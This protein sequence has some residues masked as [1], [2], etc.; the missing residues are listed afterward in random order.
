MFSYPPSSPD[1]VPVHYF[2]SPKL[3][4]ATKG[5][6]FEV[7]SSLQQTVIRELKT[8]QEDTSSRTSC[9]V[10]MSDVNVVPKEAGTILSYG[11]N[12][13]FY[14]TSV[15]FGPMLEN[16]IVTKASVLVGIMLCSLV[17]D[18]QYFRGSLSHARKQHEAGSNLLFSPKEGGSV[19]LH[20]TA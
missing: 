16:L 9:S 15:F 13:Y 14:I 4:T 6:R 18:S 8:I 11:I 5:M 20:W 19:V 7:I 3:Q 1:L 17:K 2:L 12:K 10:Y